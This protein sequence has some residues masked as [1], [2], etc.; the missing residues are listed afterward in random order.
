MRQG[1][2]SDVVTS[3]GGE[4][5]W[6]VDA[7]ADARIAADQREGENADEAAEQRLARP[8]DVA[9]AHRTER[10]IGED[11][12]DVASWQGSSDRAADARLARCEPSE[13]GS[14]GEDRR[15]SDESVRNRAGRDDEAAAMERQ[16]RQL[17]ESVLNTLDRKFHGDITEDR[18][19]DARTRPTHFE[20]DA[21]YQRGLESVYPTLSDQE[22]KGIV[23]DLRNGTEPYVDGD[24]PDL[25]QT[26][27]HERLHELS[28]PEFRD[29]FGA[30]LDEG[31]TEHLARE[32]VPGL[33]IKDQPEAYPEEERLVGMMEARV[34]PAVE[35]A[36]LNGD[37]QPLKREL[38]AQ[39]GDGAFD[40]LAKLTSEGRLNEAE[41]LILDK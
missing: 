24:R 38:D 15:A 28:D 25:P 8:I 31:A 11:K 23:G 9:A 20:S 27:A 29:R 32:A 4:V 22:R 18:L 34:G 1:D 26:V 41:K 3:D 5:P 33:H 19:R 12:S 39:L 37:I 14:V 30:G 16:Y 13:G 10:D 35:R 7:A 6:R 17:D 2:E 21:D 36:Y 40:E